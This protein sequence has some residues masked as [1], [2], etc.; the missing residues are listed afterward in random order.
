MAAMLATKVGHMHSGA[1]TSWVPSPTA[2]TL[3]ALHYH[4]VSVADVQ[5]RIRDQIPV[6]RGE[7]LEPRVERSSGSRSEDIAEELVPCPANS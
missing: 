5:A 1:S 6:A 4:E 7:L 3:H 2:A